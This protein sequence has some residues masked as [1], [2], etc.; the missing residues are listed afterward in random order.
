MTSICL[1]Y[2]AR[3]IFLMSIIY[4][5]NGMALV[6]TS[7]GN[8]R[9]GDIEYPAVGFGTYPLQGDTCFKAVLDASE[10]GYR[11]IDTATFYKNFDPIGKALK[12][13]GR[14]NFYIISKVWPDAHT[15]E[16]M[17][18]DIKTTLKKLQTSYLDA[19]LL[20]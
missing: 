16:H 4:G 5:V 3:F 20:H 17:F 9:L 13:Y 19:Y 18:E 10:V 7:E 1:R 8:C 15:P 2:M 12:K 6:I 14:E 11:I